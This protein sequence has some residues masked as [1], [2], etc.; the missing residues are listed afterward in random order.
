MLPM[1]V[2]HFLKLFTEIQLNALFLISRVKQNAFNLLISA[3][4]AEN[5]AFLMKKK[6]NLIKHPLTNIKNLLS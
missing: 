2:S 4:K 3:K 6:Y 5:F 1:N